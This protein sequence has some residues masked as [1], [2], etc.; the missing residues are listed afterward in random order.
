MIKHT[1]DAVTVP[2]AVGAALLKFAGDDPDRP[3][4]SVGIDDDAHL[5]ATDGSTA[6]RFLGCDPGKVVPT[7]R[8]RLAWGREY[9]K[10]QVAIAKA[11]KSDVEL[12]VD[13]C[14]AAPFPPLAQVMPKEKFGKSDGPIGVDA[15]Y[16]ER[17]AS[18]QKAC[19]ADRVHLTGHGD[20]G[21]PLLFM[22]E[23]K[24]PFRAEVVVMPMR[25]VKR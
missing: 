21:D 16:L 12:R 3:G 13:A 18:V 4:V 2:I 17:L 10:C 20:P 1:E 19:D 8:C 14:C 11:T 6:V 23:G 7:Q 24:A 9:L 15:A 25:T 22:V 5:C